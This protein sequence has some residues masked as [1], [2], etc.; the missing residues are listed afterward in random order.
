VCV[1]TSYFHIIANTSIV[2]SSVNNLLS[3]AKVSA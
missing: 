3:M 1:G 2:V